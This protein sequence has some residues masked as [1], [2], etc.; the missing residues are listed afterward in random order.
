MER[1]RDEMEVVNH[2]Q[3]WHLLAHIYYIIVSIL[4]VPSVHKV[5]EEPGVFFIEFTS[6][7]IGVRAVCIFF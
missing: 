4:A 5:K 3:G 2:K 7:Y 1:R 6:P